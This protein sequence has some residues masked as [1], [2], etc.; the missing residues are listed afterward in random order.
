M[1]ASGVWLLVL[2]V[3]FPIVLGWRGLAIVAIQ[4]ALCLAA[5]WLSSR[6]KDNDE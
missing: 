1:N 6:G 4:A 2:A 3:L 5:L